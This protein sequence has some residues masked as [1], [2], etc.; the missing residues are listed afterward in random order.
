MN[1]KEKESNNEYGEYICSYFEWLPISEQKERTE[2]L[3]KM[4]KNRKNKKK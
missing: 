2:E 4:T 1:E 3:D